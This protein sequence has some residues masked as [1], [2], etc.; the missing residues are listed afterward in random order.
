M[1]VCLRCVLL[2]TMLLSH[3]L[4]K[5][6]T[7]CS[8]FTE[9]HIRK[10]Q[11]MPFRHKYWS[12]S[13]KL[14]DWHPALQSVRHGF[15]FLYLSQDWTLSL[16]THCTHLKTAAIFH[17]LVMPEMHHRGGLSKDPHPDQKPDKWRTQTVILLSLWSPAWFHNDLP[18]VHYTSQ[19]LVTIICA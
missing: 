5:S 18:N 11:Y 4:V 3:I 7:T 17:K 12:S 8:R 14:R 13:F 16:N 6:Q 2:L 9:K 19:H 1:T 10:D 15:H